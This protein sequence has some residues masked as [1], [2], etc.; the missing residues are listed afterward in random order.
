MVQL[1]SMCAVPASLFVSSLLYRASFV[2]QS[3]ARSAYLTAT[4]A[5]A[6]PEKKSNLPE[7]PLSLVDR[8][9]GPAATLGAEGAL[10][11]VTAKNNIS[12]SADSDMTHTSAALRIN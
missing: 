10:A 2:R 1:M 3:P 8:S 9:I 11:A 4:T 12:T 5:V 6:L 7:S